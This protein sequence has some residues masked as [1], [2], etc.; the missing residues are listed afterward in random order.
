MCLHV[1]STTVNCS[2][3][4]QCALTHL[5]S[6]T[7][8]FEP[9]HLFSK[10]FIHFH[11]FHPFQ[12]TFNCLRPFLRHS[13]ALF[14]LQPIPNHFCE[15]LMSSHMFCAR[16]HLFLHFSAFGLK[17][18]HVT[19]TNTASL[20]LCGS[21]YSHYTHQQS[22]GGHASHARSHPA[23]YIIIH[24]LSSTTPLFTII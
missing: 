2:Q 3:V 23:T 24:G 5:P 8:V 4:L 18:S 17:L 11:H 15:P 16:S 22:R 13:Q 21:I 19:T 6:R 1:F 9:I 12:S 14:I 20:V 7:A 10:I